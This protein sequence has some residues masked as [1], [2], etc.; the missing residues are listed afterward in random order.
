M[1]RGDPMNAR[2]TV[3][4]LLFSLAVGQQVVATAQ[5][6][7]RGKAQDLSP[8]V[9]ELATPLGRE[10]QRFLGDLRQSSLDRVLRD[11]PQTAWLDP[12]DDSDDW[13]GTWDWPWDEADLEAPDQ[14]EA[15]DGGLAEAPTCGSAERQEPVVGTATAVASATASTVQTSAAATG[16]GGRMAISVAAVNGRHEIEAVLADE[17]GLRKFRASGSREEIAQWLTQLPLPLQKAIGR[18]LAEIDGEADHR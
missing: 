12:W 15:N 10:I 11:V 14:P 3:F 4:A 16:R 9:E 13:P 18:Q 2:T 5:S 7:G 8:R 1:F 17:H 6:A